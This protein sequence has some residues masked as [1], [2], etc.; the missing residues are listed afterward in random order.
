[1]K[2]SSDG[3]RVVN[4]IVF[5]SCFCATFFSDALRL[6]PAKFASQTKPLRGWS[7][8]EKHTSFRFFVVYE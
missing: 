6:S 4:G 2:E 8:S 5:H 7:G 1:M 3:S